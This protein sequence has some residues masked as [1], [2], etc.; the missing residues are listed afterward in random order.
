MYELPLIANRIFD[1]PLM[2]TQPKLEQIISVLKPRLSGEVASLKSPNAKSEK[3]LP[4]YSNEDG[5]AVISVMGTL[6][7]RA[8]LLDAESGLRSYES[9]K[10]AISEA[11]ADTSINSVL[12]EVDS[13]GGEAAGCFEFVDQLYAMRGEKPIWAAVNEW[14]CSAA[15]AIASAA[16]KIV[17]TRAASVGS[18]GV[19]SAHVDQSAYDAKLGAKWTM[20]YAG[21][22]KANGN[23]HE[24]LTDSA[25]SEYQ[26]HIN[27]TYDIFV[28]CVARN[29]GL[30]AQVVRDTEARIYMAEEAISLGLAD[31][32]MSVDAALA[33][34]QAQPTNRSNGV[35]IITQ[36]NER[37]NAMSQSKNAKKPDLTPD[38]V[39]EENEITE[40]AN[41]SAEGAE[42]S[43]NA[44]QSDIV[45]LA[46]SSTEADAGAAANELA[47][48]RDSERAR[49]AK[50]IEAAGSLQVS[51]S[52]LLELI[53]D[54]ASVE[55]G[56]KK[57]ID[58]AAKESETNGFSSAQNAEAP[59]DASLPLD[60]RCKAEWDRDPKLRQEFNNKLESYTAFKKREE[61]GQAKTFH[62]K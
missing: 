14:A 54:G 8:G 12:L 23:P 15:Y 36:S 30:G 62:K 39:S 13:G 10:G 48:A 28:N 26:R 4:A 20:I 44:A 55:D 58:R 41:A 25:L 6:T 19:I 56:Q 21:S 27:G 37:K 59:I 16:D 32:I 38:N 5:V 46:A 1:T 35:A 43:E 3:A 31:E 49:C 57:L 24:P 18:I 50:L 33:Q 51:S 2:I 22:N 29:R 61:T 52:F 60:E 53:N 11:I 17:M 42:S 40:S 34:L 9:L 45:E 47:T 7:H